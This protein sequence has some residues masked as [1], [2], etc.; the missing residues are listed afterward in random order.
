MA[1]CFLPHLLHNLLI[2]KV[3]ILI[4]LDVM[5]EPNNMD[6]PSPRQLWLLLLTVQCV[7]MSMA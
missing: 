6:F 3:V 5:H 1:V 4:G 7:N 2:N